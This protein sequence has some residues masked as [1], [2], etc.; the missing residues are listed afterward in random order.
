MFWETSSS[1][2]CLID[3]DQINSVYVQDGIAPLNYK[4]AKYI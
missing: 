1:E 4:I 3:A 2:I